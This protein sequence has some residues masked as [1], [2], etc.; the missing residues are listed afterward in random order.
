MRSGWIWT[1]G[2]RAYWL[3]FLLGIFVGFLVW[4]L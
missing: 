4:G 2:D 1:E 3:G